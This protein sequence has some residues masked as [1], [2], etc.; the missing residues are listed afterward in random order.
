MHEKHCMIPIL[1]HRLA[2]ILI[3]LHRPP[4]HHAME[5]EYCGYCMFN[6]VAI[7]AKHAIE[8]LGFKR[9]VILHV[10]ECKYSKTCIKRPLSEIHKIGFQDQ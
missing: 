7:A 6:N 1:L 5:E 3:F 2:H 10:L 9:Y 8:N 4:G